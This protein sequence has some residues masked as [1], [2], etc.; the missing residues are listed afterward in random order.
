MAKR[1]KDYEFKNTRTR[2]AF[3]EAWLDGKVWELDES[4][5]GKFG[6]AG[7]KGKVSTIRSAVA[8]YEGY[9]CFAEPNE[10]NTAVM[11][12]AFEKPKK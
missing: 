5:L 8:A 3:D 2:M 4:D 7:A 1:V 11:F 12:Q 10:T 6:T 9:G